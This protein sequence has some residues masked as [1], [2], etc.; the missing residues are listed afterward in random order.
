MKQIFLCL[1]VVSILLILGAFVGFVIWKE[2]SDAGDNSFLDIDNSSL[3]INNFQYSLT[4]EPVF[5]HPHHL[6]IAKKNGVLN[7]NIFLPFFHYVY[8]ESEM[9]ERSHSSLELKFE[10]PW[11]EANFMNIL[12]TK[13]EIGSSSTNSKFYPIMIFGG[14]Y[15]D[16]REPLS[17]RHKKGIET[18]FLRKP[19]GD[20]LILLFRSEKNNKI[21][22]KIFI[23][24]Y[25]PDFWKKI[26]SETSGSME[27][28]YS[29]AQKDKNI[30]VILL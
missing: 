11:K 24:T 20:D 14:V 9:L 6:L 18:H 5:L 12:W 22:D 1:I 3:D 27:E 29:R 8:S 19:P 7:M 21:T 26:I 23:S 10:S 17:E 13:N 4:H 30:E 25:I 2:C 28:I 16:A 15:H